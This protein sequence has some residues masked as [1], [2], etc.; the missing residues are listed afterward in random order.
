MGEYFYGM[1]RG[2][3]RKH[4]VKKAIFLKNAWVAIF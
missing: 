1:T 3:K 4:L 2:Q